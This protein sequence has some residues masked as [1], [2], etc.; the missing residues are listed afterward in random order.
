[1]LPR[2]ID[3]DDPQAFQIVYTPQKWKKVFRFYGHIPILIYFNL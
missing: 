1:M 3:E 2:C